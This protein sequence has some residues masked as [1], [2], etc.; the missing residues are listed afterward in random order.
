MALEE[1]A[2]HEEECRRLL[3]ED[4]NRGENAAAA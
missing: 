1:I 4:A 3:S 2:A